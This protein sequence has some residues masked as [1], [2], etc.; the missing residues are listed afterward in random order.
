MKACVRRRYGSHNEISILD[1]ERPVP[2]KDQVLIKVSATTVN[3]TD[4]ANLTG[5]PF[6]MHLLLGLVKP[7]RIG[8]GTDFAGTII[9]KGTAVHQFELDD[10]VFGFVD[11]GTNSQAEYL[12]IKASDIYRIPEG[13]DF[14]TAASALEGA[15]YAYTFVH[16]VS[17]KSGQSVLINGA[18]GGIG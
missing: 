8:L 5:K 6:I 11:M 18:T 2:G 16:K 15:H 12:I 9:Q 1:I 7:K 4:C 13:I 14:N 17:I 3:R 10:R